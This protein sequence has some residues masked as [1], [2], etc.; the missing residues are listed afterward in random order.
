[1]KK[2]PSKVTP[3]HLADA[4]VDLTLK[5]GGATRD[6]LLGRGFVARDLDRHI[7]QAR[8]LAA[9]DLAGRG[10]FADGAPS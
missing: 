1:M 9:A 7:D 3:A 2:S 4:L 6:D 5:T 10:L 8:R